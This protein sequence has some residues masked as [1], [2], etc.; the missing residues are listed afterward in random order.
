MYNNY[1][2]LCIKG[3]ICV[4]SCTHQRLLYICWGLKDVFEVSL[5]VLNMMLCKRDGL[6]NVL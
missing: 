5:Y 6:L 2:Y 3:T 1:E 4:V